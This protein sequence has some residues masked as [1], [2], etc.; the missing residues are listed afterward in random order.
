MHEMHKCSVRSAELLAAPICLRL[1]CR[2][3]T[4]QC[5]TAETG[6]ARQLS[7]LQ[8]GRRRRRGFGGQRWG[9]TAEEAASLG[10]VWVRQGK[11]NQAGSIGQSQCIHSDMSPPRRLWTCQLK[12]ARLQASGRGP[13]LTEHAEQPSITDRLAA[14]MHCSSPNLGLQDDSQHLLLQLDVGA[15]HGHCV[16]SCQLCPSHLTT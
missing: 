12:G 9:V 3:L 4:I 14:D 2:P 16:G 13:R 5:A 1:N 8:S 7:I 11:S 10:P 6:R 15:D